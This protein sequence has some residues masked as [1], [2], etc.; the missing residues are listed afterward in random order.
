MMKKIALLATSCAIVL[1]TNSCDVLA[2][3]DPSVLDQISVPLTEKEA[4]DGLKEALMEGVFHAV[5]VGSASNG[6]WGNEQLQIPWPEEALKV[7]T[8]LE[9]A[10]FSNL[11]EQFEESMNH[12]AESATAKA[13]PVFTK[14]I[15]EMTVADA[16]DLVRGEDNA[17]TLYLKNK[18]E[19]ELKVAFEPVVEQAMGEGKVTELWSKLVTTYNK[20]PLTKDVNA[21]LTGYITERTL[22]GVFLLVEEQEKEIRDN[23]AARVTETLKRVFGS[24]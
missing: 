1:S 21:D 8:T 10:G 23:P 15:K 14:A 11:T 7:K 17:A 16:L 3:L 4:V 18:T 5:E 24:K 2:Q 19:S 20:I 13:K 22:N 9:K 12:A 6:F